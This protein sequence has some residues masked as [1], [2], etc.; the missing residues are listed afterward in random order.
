MV[1]LVSG[2]PRTVF[3]TDTVTNR[4]VEVDEE[5]GDLIDKE[6]V[7]RNKDETVSINRK[8][9]TESIEMLVSEWG[10]YVIETVEVPITKEEQDE[11]SEGNRN[12]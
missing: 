12:D 9:R 2:A 3:A 1:V 8:Q 5:R 11:A 6:M 4:M 10:G 7:L